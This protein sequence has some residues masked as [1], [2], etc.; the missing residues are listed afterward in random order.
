MYLDA[1]VKKKREGIPEKYKKYPKEIWSDIATQPAESKSRPFYQ[2]I[3]R[4][5]ISII[6]EIKQA[7]PSLGTIKEELNLQEILEEYNTSVEALSILTE[8]DYFKGHPD[9]IPEV[10]RYS[11]LPKLMKDFVI[12]PVQLY[13]ARSLG[14]QAVLLIAA[15]L[16]REE[17]ETFYN[18]ARSLDLDVL[19]EI[20]NEE[21]LE[22]AL[23]I[24]ADIIGINNRDLQSFHVDVATTGRLR[25]KIPSG[26]LVV[27]ES[28]IRH[29]C[30]MV[31]LKKMNVDGVLI[32]EAFMKAPSISAKAEAL[33]NV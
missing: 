33:K 11:K 24:G 4:P 17:L 22:K 23:A 18:L 2:A 15:I 12:D 32:G 21:D 3:A 8:E 30:H 10:A 14:A 28:G 27:S 5:G 31:Y 29:A 25:E 13:E 20:H 9:R 16:S 7:S 1:I 6:G 19:L 26:I